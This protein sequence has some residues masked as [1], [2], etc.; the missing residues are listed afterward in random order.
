[1]AFENGLF[2]VMLDAAGGDVVE[3][4]LHTADPGGT[5]ASEVAGGSYTRQAVTW[6]PASGASVAAAAPIV[7]DVPASTTVSHLG[8]WA[9]GGVWRGSIEF[10]SPE[11]FS[12]AGQLT[13]SPTTISLTN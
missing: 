12:G 2:N 1:M 13:V 9:A 7:F 6:E 5:G 8:L 11:S 3:A 10:A 4:S